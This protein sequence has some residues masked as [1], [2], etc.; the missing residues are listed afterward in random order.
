MAGAAEGKVVA[1]LFAPAGDWRCETGSNAKR[2]GRV[3]PGSCSAGRDSE[4]ILQ[5][6]RNSVE[7]SA[8][9]KCRLRVERGWPGPPKAKLSPIFSLLPETGM[10][11]QVSRKM[12]TRFVVEDYFP[13]VYIN[14]SIELGY[15]NRDKLRNAYHHH[16]TVLAG[17]MANDDPA[18]FRHFHM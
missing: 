10:S 7:S 16:G 1:N 6:P 13:V 3:A 15:H 5:G 9:E 11:R 17:T 14:P 18:M 2:A 8:S 4:G 12:A